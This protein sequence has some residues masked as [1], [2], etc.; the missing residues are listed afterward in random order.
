METALSNG[1]ISMISASYTTQKSHAVS[2]QVD[3]T[4]ELTQIWY[5]Q[6]VPR[7]IS[8]TDLCSESSQNPNTDHCWFTEEAVKDLPPP[9]SNDVNQT[10]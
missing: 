1:L 6:A 2:T 5:L 9:N 4:L 8:L 3:G 10:Y 7:V